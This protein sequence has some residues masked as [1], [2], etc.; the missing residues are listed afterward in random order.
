M[1]TPHRKVPWLHQDSNQGTSCCE[2][3]SEFFLHTVMFLLRVLKFRP[4]SEYYHCR[5][6]GLLK[7]TSS[8]ESSSALFRTDGNIRG[9]QRKSIM[10]HSMSHSIIL[11]LRRAHV[12]LI[13]SVNNVELDHQ[14]FTS[15]RL[16]T[17]WIY[18]FDLSCQVLY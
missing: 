3:R 2:A 18:N 15:L 12:Q 6:M 11:E 5:I 4:F 9:A 8:N 14:I 13:Q 16:K 17:F 1:Q 7:H 10:S